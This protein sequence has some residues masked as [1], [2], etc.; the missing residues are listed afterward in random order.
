[1]ERRENILPDANDM[2]ISDRR[3]PHLGNPGLDREVDWQHRAPYLS[4]WSPIGSFSCHGGHCRY[5]WYDGLDMYV[6]IDSLDTHYTLVIK[7]IYLLFILEKERM[8]TR[9]GHDIIHYIVLDILRR[10]TQSA[11]CASSRDD[12]YWNRLISML[13]T[14]KISDAKN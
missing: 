2:H 7:S 6:R 10:P 13:P 11:V 14:K 8:G 3:H 5:R 4:R 1:M 12:Y 9:P